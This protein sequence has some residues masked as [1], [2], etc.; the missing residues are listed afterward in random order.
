MLSTRSIRWLQWHSD[1][2]VIQAA[3][4]E[5]YILCSRSKETFLLDAIPHLGF[6]TP[7]ILG[8][9]SPKNDAGVFFL[10]SLP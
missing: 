8:A 9:L 5:S 10:G 4:L 6:L 1:C 3:Q 7:R 2:V